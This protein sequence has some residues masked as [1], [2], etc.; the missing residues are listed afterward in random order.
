MHCELNVVFQFNILPSYHTC[1]NIGDCPENR[2]YY[3]GCCEMCNTTGI[4]KTES[5]SLCAPESLPVNQT[6]GLVTEDNP[7]HD[8]C[9]NMEA[10]V[11]FTE[12]RGLCD[13]YTY[14][15]KSKPIEFDSA[16]CCNQGLEPFRFFGTGSG[17]KKI[18]VNDSGSI[19]MSIFLLNIGY[20]F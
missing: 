12:C 10:I 6:L 7:F 8:T 13:S 20:Q 11:G 14:F 5:H 16:P 2:I 9:T 18:N 4:M 17:S 1:P 19:K 15:N 3:D